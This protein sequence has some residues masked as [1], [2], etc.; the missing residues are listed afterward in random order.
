MICCRSEGAGRA[1][2]RRRPY[3]KEVTLTIE[4]S[5]VGEDVAKYAHGY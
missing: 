4:T 2:R 1:G 3:A 5:I